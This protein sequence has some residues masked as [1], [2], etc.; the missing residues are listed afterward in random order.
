MR[1]INTNCSY[2]LYT[3]LNLFRSVFQ[4]CFVYFFQNLASQQTFKQIKPIAPNVPCVKFAG[5]W[6]FRPTVP[7]TFAA[8]LYH[9]TSSRYKSVAKP[10]Q[11]QQPGCGARVLE[12]RHQSALA[13]SR[14]FWGLVRRA[15]APFIHFVSV[16]CGEQACFERTSL[17]G[18][19]T[20][21]QT[22]F[23]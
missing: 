17:H 18:A 8:H 7:I 11:L 19:V 15:E 12:A 21:I 1:N 22:A 23:G 4:H 5:G 10:L 16:F 2:A 20:V 13:G 3:V 6:G 9:H 14:L